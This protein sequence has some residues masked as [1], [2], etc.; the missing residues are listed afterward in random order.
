MHDPEKVKWDRS[1]QGI[2]WGSHREGWQDGVSRMVPGKES[3][4]W[5]VQT[6]GNG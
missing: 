2:K 4:G 6:E 5:L 3:R 1:G